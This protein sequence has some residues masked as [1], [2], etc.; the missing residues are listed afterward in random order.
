[1]FICGIDY[2]KRVCVSIGGGL[3]HSKSP[4]PPTVSGLK[5][6]CFFLLPYGRKHAYVHLLQS[7]LS[8]TT[9]MRTILFKFNATYI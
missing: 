9:P 7:K 3:G 4:M 2:S 1:M 5:V 8:V 6:R